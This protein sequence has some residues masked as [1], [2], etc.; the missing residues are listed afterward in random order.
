MCHPASTRKVLMPMID[1]RK[2]SKVEKAKH[3]IYHPSK[4]FHPGQS[5]P[6]SGYADSIDNESLLF[7]RFAPLHHEVVNTILFLLQKVNY[8]KAKII[9]INNK[10]LF[11]I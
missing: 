5:A 9:Q 7:N 2:V 6:Y 11:N 8:I 10:Y 3:S 4:T 1:C